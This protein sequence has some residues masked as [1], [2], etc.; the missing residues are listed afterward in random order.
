MDRVVRAMKDT[1]VRRVTIGGGVAANSEIRAKLQDLCADHSIAF[2]APPL[3][4]CTDNAAMI[5]HA[6][7]LR[8]VAGE[9]HGLDRVARAQW[10]PG[11]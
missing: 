8:L 5:A 6:G 7:R 4:Y 1:G 2:N 9:R 3:K 11:A 10:T